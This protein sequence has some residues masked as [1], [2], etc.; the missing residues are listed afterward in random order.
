MKKGNFIDQMFI[1]TVLRKFD[2][3][4]QRYGGVN[5]VVRG[6]F[7][8]NRESKKYE[9]HID[10]ILAWPIENRWNKEL[11]HFSLQSH[12]TYLEKQGRTIRT[13]ELDDRYHPFVLEFE[14]SKKKEEYDVYYEV[15]EYL[16]HMMQKYNVA[17]T[18]IA[19]TITNS[20]SIYVWINPKVFGLKP[21][22]SVHRIYTEMYKKLKKELSLKFVDE[23]VVSSSYR[24]IKT[25]GSFYNG[26]YVNYITV[27]EL[28]HLM[29]GQ[30][31]REELTKHQRDIRKLVLPGIKSLSLTKLYEESKKKVEKKLK[32]LK[33]QENVVLELPGTVECCRKC[34]QE[35]INMPLIEKG[36]RN[37][38]LVTIDLGLHEANYSEKEILEVLHRKATEWGHDESLR[39]VTN[40]YKA[41]KRN[42][43]N[44]S[45]DK[46]KMLFAEEG[47]NIGCGSCKKAINE[48]IY[49]AR[50]IIEKIYNNKGSVRHYRMYLELEKQHL[51]GKFFSLE[52][53]NLN[54]R[55]L[56]ELA[57]LTK[58]TIEK[59]DGLFKLTI[60]RGKAVYRL[61]LEY[62]ENTVDVLDQ[63]I[64]KVLMLIVKAYS[65]NE[66]GAF[67]SLSMA[68]IAEYLCFKSESGAY[69][70]V[71]ELE[72][73]GFLTRNKNN[74]GITIYY[75]SRKVISLEEEREVRKELNKG[76]IK[77][78]KV[79]NGIQIK[80][81]FEKIEAGTNLQERN[82]ENYKF[83]RIEGMKERRGSPPS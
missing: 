80:F 28:M 79:V 8:Q 34:V 22:K 56:K 75:K 62:I 14:S 33:K 31:T 26:G 52:S 15:A 44:F 12:F 19:I 61:P 10:K 55:T 51:L 59:K 42:G 2:N 38:F 35:L 83:N 43:T 36:N 65:G 30:Q 78:L 50:N 49:I 25:P 57:Q 20:K 45:C 41:L 48:S 5:E 70:F 66:Y 76:E 18:D 24:L 3:T 9:T 16:Q 47:I 73:L 46:V 7:A 77:N 68:K 60:K 21:G 54:E 64:G 67:V 13:E 17:K 81:D 53:V 58:G 29:T 6:E 40:K 69:R 71:K 72:G 27:D 74:K 1:Y 39:A 32:S 82:F 11:S 23:S 37:N 4:I 63:K